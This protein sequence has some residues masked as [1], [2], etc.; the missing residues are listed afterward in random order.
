M[1]DPLAVA[2]EHL[3][4]AKERII[5]AGQS[6][7]TASRGRLLRYGAGFDPEGHANRA[8]WARA[9]LNVGPAPGQRITVDG[10]PSGVEALEAL[11]HT[12]DAYMSAHHIEAF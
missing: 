2:D 8:W 1:P 6:V 7:A 12:I 3:A 4:A 5:R 9:H 11:A 10:F